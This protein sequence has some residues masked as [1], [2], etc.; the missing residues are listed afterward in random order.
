MKKIA[1]T[2]I[3]RQSNGFSKML[4]ARKYRWH[5]RRERPDHLAG[6]RAMRISSGAAAAAFAVARVIFVQPDVA[7]AQSTPSALTKVVFSLDFIPLGRHAAWYAAVT[8]GFFREEGLDVSII[9][10]QGGAQVI[11]NVAAGTANLGFMGVPEV[12]IAR[13]T[14]A[15]L[16]IVS[17]IY[18]KQPIAVFSLQSGANVTTAKQLEGLTLASG[19]GSFTPKILQ[20]FMAGKGL[21]PSTLH[22]TDIAPPARPG[23]LIT[24]KVP[25]IETFIMGKPGLEQAAEDAHEKLQTFIPANN[26]LQLYSN[27]IGVTEEYLSQHPHV[28][29]GFV[30]AALKGWKFALDH[31]AKAAQDELQYVQSLKPEVIAAELNIV[32]DLVITPDTQEHGLGWFDPA[33]IKANVD[34]VTKYIGITGTPPAPAD[35]Y[36]TGFLPDPPIKP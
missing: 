15:K 3:I 36:A 23:A 33:Q 13:S 25:S 17:V 26:G 29:R 9:P 8:E 12:A 21:D 5:D 28:V 6:E 19:S 32:R 7:A 10:S 27:G 22:I 14:G 30:R 16:K 35:M 4:T 20:G 2:S 24:K 1:Y 31:P 18:Q 11:Q 34:F